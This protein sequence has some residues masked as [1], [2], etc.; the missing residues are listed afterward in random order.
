MKSAAF[1][2][3]SF[4]ELPALLEALSTGGEDARIIAGGQ[5]L[6][7]LMNMRLA[8]P[9]VLLDINGISEL[10][11]IDVDGDTIM[12]GAATT[13]REVLAW[14][15]LPSFSPLLASA[16]P[17]IGY[18]AIR[19]RGTV[20]G[21][22]ASADPAAEFG[23]CALCLAARLVLVSTRGTRIINADDFFIGAMQTRLAPDEIVT[24]IDI[25]VASLHAR[26]A[27]VEAGRRARDAAICGV[28]LSAVPTDQGLRQVRIALA[29][30]GDRPVLAVKAGRIAENETRLPDL[31]DLQYAIS[32]EIDVAS[33]AAIDA[34]LRLRFA[35]VLTHRTLKE[36]TH[37]HAA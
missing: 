5:S 8:R 16:I 1:S 13:Y 17:H 9:S 32:E 28:A 34:D 15:A 31:A 35:S 22:L 33:D 36:L 14:P 6:V 7:P 21:S 11:G 30:V 12:I 4:R 2:Y 10:R 25:P 20:G 26:F 19:N 27:F 37:G 23:A 3:R 29:G 24:R 18:P